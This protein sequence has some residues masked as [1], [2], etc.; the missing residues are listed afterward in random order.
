M[1]NGHPIAKPPAAKYWGKPAGRSELRQNTEYVLTATMQSSEQ[2]QTP[3]MSDVTR[4]QHNTRFLLS[5]FIRQCQSHPPRW[6]VYIRHRHSGQTDSITAAVT[7]TLIPTA[8]PTDRPTDIRR[9]EHHDITR[10][11]GGRLTRDYTHRPRRQTRQRILRPGT[12][13]KYCDEY[14]PNFT[15]F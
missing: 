9:L 4:R 8:A 7:H 3:T 14:R 1:L 15:N 11:G 10:E 13:A 5:S 6:L 2:R 12:A